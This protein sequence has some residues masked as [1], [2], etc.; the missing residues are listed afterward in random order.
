MAGPY[1]SLGGDQRA[2]P[3]TTWGLL[4]GMQPGAQRQQEFEVLCR[5]YWKPIYSFVRSAWRKSDA[6]AKDLTQAYFMWLMESDVL[7][8]YQ[9]EVSSFRAYLKGVLRNFLRGQ[10]RHA[11]RVKRGGAA[12]H[13]PLQSELAD[14]SEVL[15]DPGAVSPEEAF[16]RAWFRELIARGT[17]RARQEALAAGHEVRFK[18]FE[19][20]DL[21]PAGTKPTYEDV[22]APYGLGRT[23]V[24]NHL[25]A[26]RE[27]VRN[28]IRAELRETVA[29]NEQLE[30]EWNE[31][32]G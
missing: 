6:D 31:L 5:R 9:V 15:P 25:F 20:Y 17:E 23:A 12:A 22:G 10:D 4:A 26:M 11:G 30:A 24:R 3:P 14:L 27:Q 2:F 19:A 32:F 28:A 21:A 29:T 16:D 7:A 18:L 1:T 13:L 8:R